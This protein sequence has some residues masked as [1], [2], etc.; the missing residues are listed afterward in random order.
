MVGYPNAILNLNSPTIPN[1]TKMA[2]ILDSYLF[3]QYYN[4]RDHSYSYGP[5][6]SSTEPSQ[7][8]T[9]KCWVFERLQYSRLHCSLDFESCP[10]SVLQLSNL[11]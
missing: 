5:D 3:I 4:G 8:K 6:H 9:L 11:K 1:L 2:D 7:I 10:K